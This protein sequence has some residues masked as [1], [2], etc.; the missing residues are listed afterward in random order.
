MKALV[1]PDNVVWIDG[2]NEQAEQLRQEACTTGELIKLNKEMCI[3]DRACIT[4]G[5]LLTTV[6]HV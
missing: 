2:S 6:A 1:K 5:I 4:V 3:R